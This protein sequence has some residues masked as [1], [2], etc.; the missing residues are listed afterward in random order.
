MCDRERG[1][2]RGQRERDRAR[3]VEAG[4]GGVDGKRGVG[5]KRRW[6]ASERASMDTFASDEYA[7]FENV[8]CIQIYKSI[9]ALLDY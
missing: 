9:D 7:Y 6:R 1:T 5:K 8:Y 4:K 3:G 2:G